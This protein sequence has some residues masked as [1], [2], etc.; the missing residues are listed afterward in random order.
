V[1]R[2]EQLVVAWLHDHVY[3]TDVALGR[4]LTVHREA[5]QGARAC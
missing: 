4:W 2:L 5:S 1:L 3:F